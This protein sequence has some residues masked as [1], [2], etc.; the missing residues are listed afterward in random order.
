MKIKVTLEPNIEK[1]THDLSFEDL[2]HTKESWDLL[3]E[4]EK[5]DI[6]YEV[7]C[8]NICG[9]ITSVEQI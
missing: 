5:H 3:S 2:D 6:I 1:D 9:I 7:I 8:D 4:D